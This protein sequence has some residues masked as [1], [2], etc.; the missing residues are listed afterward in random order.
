VLDLFREILALTGDSYRTELHA[1]LANDEYVVTLITNRAERDGKE[2]ATDQARVYR[3]H[4]GKVAQVWGY[5]TDQY[6]DDEF[7][8]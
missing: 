2:T 7:L 1:V 5:L 3:I 6:A 4:D 8:S